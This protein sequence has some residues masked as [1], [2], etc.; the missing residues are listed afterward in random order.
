M[1]LVALLAAGLATAGAEVAAQAQ[2]AGKNIAARVG[3]EVITRDALRAAVQER[4]AQRSGTSTPS[5]DEIEALSAVVLDSL[6]ERSMIVQDARRAL[7]SP[8]RIQAVYENSDRMWRQE[9]LPRLLRRMSAA[10]EDDLR[11]RLAARGRSLDQ[12][13]TNFREDVLVKAYIAHKLLAKASVTKRELEDYYKT[14]INDFQRPARWT[15]REVTVVIDNHPSRAAARSKAA[16]TLARL[17]RGDDFAE[18]AQRESE[19]SNRTSG[20]LRETPPNGSAVAAVNAALR[21]L[22][23]GQL[24]GIIVGPASYHIVRVDARR[25]AGPAPFSEVQN[26][27]RT[28]I[29]G[30]KRDRVAIGYFEDLQTRYVV[31]KM[32]DAGAVTR[33]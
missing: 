6:I 13:R 25:A 16:A 30:E 8:D 1:P 31:T 7:E 24:S 28:R 3:D 27:I 23:V 19:G 20:G 21:S 29:H 32:D 11:T 17:E 33:R 26:A 4:L 9:E 12:I 2:M 10:N 14:H 22:P 18:V 15:W 5:H